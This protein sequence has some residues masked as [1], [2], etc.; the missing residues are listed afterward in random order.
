MSE[1]V[2]PSDAGVVILVG[3]E[4]IIVENLDLKNNYH[5]VLLINSSSIVIR[6]NNITHNWAN[7]DFYS[8]GVWATYGSSNITVTQN[9]VLANDNGV[10]LWGKNNTVSVNN[11]ANNFDSGVTVSDDSIVTQNNITGN[12]GAG[13]WIWG[14][15]CIVDSNNLISNLARGV[16]VVGSNNK[17][18]SNN[19]V[20]NGNPIENIYICDHFGI[21]LTG[22][23]NNTIHSN[24]IVEC[25]TSAIAINGASNN[26][27]YHNNFINNNKDLKDIGGP[28]ASRV[29]IWDNGYPSG[30]NYWSKYN[31]T[32]SNGDGIG[33]TP[34]ILDSNNTDIYPLINPFN[35][36]L[37]PQ[38]YN[39]TITGFIGNS[40]IEG[41]YDTTYPR[42]GTYIFMANSTI[43]VDTHLS[44]G[45]FVDRWEFN[46]ENVGSDSFVT[47]TIDKNYALSVF[48]SV[49]P[50]LNVSISP[51]T[52]KIEVGEF[53]EFNSSV[54]GGKPPYEFQWRINGSEVW[55]ASS[56]IWTFKPEKPGFYNV[57]LHVNY[58]FSICI[59]SET[60][61]VTVTAR[62]DFD[63]DRKVGLSDLVIMA[64]AYGSRPGDPNWNPDTD[65]D[66]NGV[67]GLSDL[68][69]LAK[70][71]GRVYP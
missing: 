41:F 32:D 36:N 71:Y 65:T 17:I 37:P 8:G 61:L 52:A 39:L 26:T 9:N 10:S 34:Y 25:G 40:T 42:P 53:L 7:W 68:V 16:D 15:N 44:Y 49:V 51:L 50:P 45:T 19:I 4:N 2:V 58:P 46:G 23:I 29:N 27:I 33:D 1:K 14:S 62:C 11:I 47:L 55:N 63:G 22:A 28:S 56:S 57:S 21:L 31:G 48:L 54:S 35:G 30:G 66:G 5:G 3:C 12:Q 6:K 13:V 64:K 60:S 18:I 69:I 59:K 43:R 24:N 67:V 38:T 70:N 20:G